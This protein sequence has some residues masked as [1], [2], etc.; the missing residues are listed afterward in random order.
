MMEN[1][2]DSM[3]DGSHLVTSKY[4]YYVLLQKLCTVCNTC[5]HT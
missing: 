4:N 1:S 5:F 2:T 3:I